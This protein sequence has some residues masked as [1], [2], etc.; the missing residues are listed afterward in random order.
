MREGIVGGIFAFG[1]EDDGSKKAE[2][3][4]VCDAS[5]WRLL[6]VHLIGGCA[7]GQSE[8]LGLLYVRVPILC[9]ETAKDGLAGRKDVHALQKR[10]NNGKSKIKGKCGGFSTARRTVNLSVASVEMTTLLVGD[11][12]VGWKEQAR[13]TAKATAD[14]P[15]AAKDDN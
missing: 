7:S 4:Q 2:D 11:L 12:S 14:P 9:G 1:V 15:P 8:F 10:N 3:E 13:A 5:H 6:M